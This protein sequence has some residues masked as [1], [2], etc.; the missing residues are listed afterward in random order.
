MTLN[1]WDAIR[2]NEAEGFATEVS[3]PG[4]DGGI[5]IFAGRGPL[6]LDSPKLIVQVKS[7]TTA[8]N[9]QV[10][11]ELQ[12]VLSTHGAEQALLV[13]AGGV[14]RA[15]QRELRSQF[16]QIRAWDEDDLLDAILRNYERLDEEWRS[17][18]PL[19]RIWAPAFEPTEWLT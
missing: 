14:N 11:R 3:P 12:G 5:D 6:G 18:L 15:A 7:G 9:V 10:V 16:F 17:E 19:K 8:V 13:A 1:V 4:P 2:S